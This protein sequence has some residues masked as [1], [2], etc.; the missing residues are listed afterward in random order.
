M[1]NWKKISLVFGAFAIV[2]T[3]YAADTFKISRQ[4]AGIMVQGGTSSTTGSSVVVSDSTTNEFKI[5]VVTAAASGA[6][7]S[8]TNTFATSFLATPTAVRG[9]VSGQASGFGSASV[10]T[11][12]PSNMV[13]TALSTN[14]SATNSLPFIVYGT[15]RSGMLQ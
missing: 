9:V 13:V 4:T 8:S 12:T 2:A 15:Q 5:I 14:G 7:T 3:L 10:V 1:K 6:Q 11:L